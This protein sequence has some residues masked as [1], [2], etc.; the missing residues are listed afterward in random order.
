MGTA[1]E[2]VRIESHNGC[3]FRPR[4]GPTLKQLVKHVRGPPRHEASSG[5]VAT[6]DPCVRGPS[7]TMT[8]RDCCNKYIGPPS[9]VKS[10]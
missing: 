1:S 2:I 10:E 4:V 7:W 3:S 9:R 5:E 6:V 8:M